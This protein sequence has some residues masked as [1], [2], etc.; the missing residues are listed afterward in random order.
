MA[1]A[2]DEVI[3]IKF[4]AHDDIGIAT[5]ELVV[6]DESAKDEKGEPKILAVKEI[7]L[8]DQEL[9]R[10]VMGITKLDLKE[11]NL[12][13]G[14]NISYAIRVAD[15]RD[16]QLDLEAMA[17]RRALTQA[18]TDDAKDSAT[19]HGDRTAAGRMM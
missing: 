9:A 11:L 8:G 14:T 16:L 2:V 6:Y 4:E 7:E 18:E 19:D 3:D 13:E 17:A 1:V 5:A 10:H 15:N 12:R